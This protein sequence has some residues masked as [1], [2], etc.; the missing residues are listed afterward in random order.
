MRWSPRPI[1]SAYV[2]AKHGIAGLDQDGG[3]G[4]S[5]PT[6]S[7]ST[8]S[9]PGYVW[10]PLVEADP[11]D[12]EGARHDRGAGQAA[13]CCSR[14]SRP[15]EF[16]T[17]EQVA[18]AGALPAAADAAASHHAARSAA[19]TAAGRLTE[20]LRARLFS[21]PCRMPSAK[22]K[23]FVAAYGPSSNPAYPPGPYRF[24]DREYAIISYHSR[25]G[26]GRPSCRSRWRS[27]TPSLKYEFIR[28]PRPRPASAT[29]PRPGGSS[30]SAS[31]A[32]EGRLCSRHVSR[33]RCAD[34][35]RAR[36][37][38]GLPRSREAQARRMKAR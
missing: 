32:R 12:D 7:P 22:P 28:M 21:F 26:R 13:T 6:A 8:R 27:S 10:T 31:R 17:V 34:H 33:R 20:A 30:P 29:T 35:R 5:R 25:P 36:E 18:G 4:E 19:S 2:A 37:I 3:P 14:R 38:Q 16:V 23:T 9:R 15:S 1:K 11:D 24:C